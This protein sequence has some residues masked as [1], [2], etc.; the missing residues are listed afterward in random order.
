MAR[1]GSAGS[2]FKMRRVTDSQGRP[3]YVYF[4]DAGNQTRVHASEQAARDELATKKQ[5][6]MLED[7]RPVSSGPM[8]REQISQGTARSSEVMEMQPVSEQGMTQRALAQS[9]PPQSE[10]EAK[11]GPAQRGR[12]NFARSEP[13]SMEERFSAPSRRNPNEQTIPVGPNSDI[14][15]RM[16]GTEGPRMTPEGLKQFAA[17]QQIQ[18]VQG[19]GA[20][21]EAEEKLG[22]AQRGRRAPLMEGSDTS[23]GMVGEQ[24]SE[25]QPGMLG[26]NPALA[27][28]NQA[29]EART[30]D[31]IGQ[32]DA[33]EMQA[34]EAG[35]QKSAEV[36]AQQMDD[37]GLMNTERQEPKQPDDPASAELSQLN[38]EANSQN[39]TKKAKA[40]KER[41]DLFAGLSREERAFAKEELGNY[42]IDPNSGLAINLDAMRD[43]GERRA[44]MMMLDYIPEH[45]RASMLASWGYI[46]KEDVEGLPDDPKTKRLEMELLNK[47]TLK[48]M[49]IDGKKGIIGE[50][51]KG[52][53]GI[54]KLRIR[55][56]SDLAKQHN[57]SAEKM[58]GLK[59]EHDKLIQGNEFAHIKDQS[60]KERAVRKYLQDKHNISAENIQNIIK[61]MNIETKRMD[62]QATQYVARQS[63]F[64]QKEVQ[65][66]IGKW[67]D[68]IATKQIA[69][70]QTLEEL[71]AASLAE[72]A[73]I[74][75]KSQVEVADM[76]GMWNG[77]LGTV[78]AD[79]SRDVATTQA[80][81]TRYVSDNQVKMKTL[82]TTLA[83]DLGME[84]INIKKAWNQV[85][86]DQGNRKLTIEEQMA[87]LKQYMGIAD[88]QLK[89]DQEARLLQSVKDLHK[90]EWTKIKD[91]TAFLNRQLGV[92]EK[93]KDRELSIA[94]QKVAIA[95]HN[96][97]FTDYKWMMDNDQWESA[98]ILAKHDGLLGELAPNG[99][100]K[101]RADARKKA[102]THGADVEL[103]QALQDGGY[104]TKGL[105]PKD[106]NAVIGKYH[107]KRANVVS[108]LMNT[109]KTDENGDNNLQGAMKRWGIPPA[110]Q[111]PRNEEGKIVWFNEEWKDE[112]AYRSAVIQEVLNKEM[113]E[114]YPGLHAGLERRRLKRLIGSS[115]DGATTGSDK[116]K[117]DT[118][119]VAE[120]ISS[121]QQIEEIT[122]TAGPDFEAAYSE[123]QA[124]IKDRL[125]GRGVNDQQE[126]LE[127]GKGDLKQQMLRFKKTLGN[128][129][130]APARITKILESPQQ[131]V[132]HF[133]SHPKDFERLGTWAKY[134]V[135]QQA[136]NQKKWGSQPSPDF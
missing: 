99:E 76:V 34:A 85:L 36:A 107:T 98:A 55:A 17:R 131:I 20:Q 96:Q 116:V 61:D 37:A 40:E 94:D 104:V 39:P 59:S 4:D 74:T 111:A 87:V 133:T 102:S 32:M 5:Q 127:T 7:N 16:T 136:Q 1:Y 122:E 92:T 105:K 68:T 110:E 38:K 126:A 6:M 33:T 86:K 2:D 95:K 24:P 67:K 28:I 115:W 81:A 118:P 54:E 93:L 50:E 51:Y 97:L 8:I 12:T 3:G 27:G 57:V 79:A 53:V 75:G 72:V 26:R 125:L 66:V 64:G 25:E 80:G 130:M 121:T 62:M 22:P 52:R 103:I 73:E 49:D 43:D 106:V 58:F 13:F 29:D 114:A 65:E 117:K 129:G 11:S 124:G 45:Q 82:E 42:H 18:R 21:S 100:A 84:E 70:N 78:R 10:A 119:E 47:I 46:D 83:R 44:N 9:R 60:K 31:A 134:Y 108:E 120:E 63:R 30:R 69:G 128:G 132:D 19:G 77:Y 135:A 88:V 41:K 14:E 89:Q 71:R 112:N 101:I 91:N 48:T 15:R 90:R 23:V 109:V 35:S 56:A 123:G 113:N